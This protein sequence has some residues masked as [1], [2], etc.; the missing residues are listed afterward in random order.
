MRTGCM[1]AFPGHHC[2]ALHVALHL[3]MASCSFMVCAQR[4][5]A[6]LMTAASLCMGWRTGMAQQPEQLNFPQDAACVSC[7]LKDVG[8]ALNGDGGAGHLVRGSAYRAIASTANH[9][10]DAEPWPAGGAA[11][12]ALRAAT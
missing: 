8:D 11:S 4:T 1:H 10:M 5:Q 6:A 2:A 12:S 7:V 3:H 9:F